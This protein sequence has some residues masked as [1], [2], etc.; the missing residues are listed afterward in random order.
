MTAPATDHARVGR[1][2]AV[3]VGAAIV[4][5]SALSL[6][7]LLSRAR[8]T[9]YVQAAFHRDGPSGDEIVF[10]D[11]R[12]APGDAL[13]LEIDLSRRIFVYVLSENDRGQAFLL[14][15]LPGCDLANPLEPGSHRL[16]GPWAGLEARWQVT[17]AG[18]REHFLIVASPH[19]FLVLEDVAR[20]LPR[21]E[22]GRPGVA[23]PLDEATVRRL[24]GR[25]G[26]VEATVQGPATGAPAAS[27]RL[28]ALARQLGAEGEEVRG[29]WVRAVHFQNP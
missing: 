11:S 22:A 3:A 18:E 2:V 21:G 23:A 13:S 19:P 24:R 17:S 28:A 12:V 14:F 1:W 5:L 10:S 16:P 25:G 6:G 29:V 8:A 20:S 15:P 9:Y 27:G 26:V 7:F 4:A